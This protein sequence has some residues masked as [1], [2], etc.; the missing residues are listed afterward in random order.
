MNPSASQVLAGCANNL[1]L[2]LAASARAEDAAANGAKAWPDTP[3][4]RLEALALLQ[5]LNAD[6]LSNDSATLTL[7]R[8]CESHRMATPAKIVAERVR[9]QDKDAT[10]EVRKLLGIETNA[11]VRYCHVRLRCGS[12]VL[13]EADNWYV[14]ARLTADMNRVLDTS[15]TPFGRAVQAL[16][17]HRHTLSAHLLWSPLP[18][19]WEMQKA[20]PK[21]GS[22]PLQVPA[23]LIQHRAVLSLPDGTPISLVVE[24]YTNQVLAFPL[25]GPSRCPPR[26]TFAGRVACFTPETTTR[27]HAIGWLCGSKPTGD[28]THITSVPVRQHPTA[29]TQA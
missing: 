15:D 1:W 13:S 22:G 18:Q 2:V 9:D 4:T 7:D 3:G 6:L 25:P 11:P 10:D 12:H 23:E 20:L 24:T 5:T 27:R 17:F 19:G 16:N 29:P 21:P 8:W 28:P 14:P 26:L